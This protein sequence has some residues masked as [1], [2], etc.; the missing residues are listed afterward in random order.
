VG[1]VAIHAADEG[2]PNGST[3]QLGNTD[4]AGNLKVAMPY[5]AWRFEVTART[6]VGSWPQPVLDTTAADPASVQV[7][8]N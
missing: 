6:P 8:V 4:A 2:C 5:G 1:V 3:L 7:N